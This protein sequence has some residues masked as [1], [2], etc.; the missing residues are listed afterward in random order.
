[1]KKSLASLCIVSIL[2]IFSACQSSDLDYYTGSV[3][4]DSY[5]VSTEVGG[6][7][8]EIYVK[9]GDT[10]KKGDKLARINVDS[11]RLELGR[12]QAQSGASKAALDKTFKG[13]RSEEI[14]KAR[15][16]VNQQE[17]VV[18][19]NQQDYNYRLEN[20]NTIAQLYESD[21]ASEQSL[22]D[23]KAVLDAASSKLESSRQQLAY[24]REQL[25][26]VQNG[27]TKE[28]IDISKSNLDA[29][30]W[31]IKSLEDNIAKEFVYANSDGVIESL[32][33]LGGEYAPIF[34][35][36]ANINNLSNLWVK[37]Y[38]EEKNLGNVKLGKE[39]TM[40][41][42]LDGADSIKGKVVYI[43]SE[44]EFT[45]KNIESKENKQ[46]IVYEVKIKVLDHIDAVKPGV[47][48]D[49]YL[50]DSK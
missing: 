26:L 34:T 3:E 24:L 11:L 32:N 1:M 21:A 10:V 9:E 28:D 36:I 39:V 23:S 30:Q 13:S 48:V 2:F 31:S 8:E 49:V 16:Q 33:Y 50:G 41:A 46:E 47:L 44:G 4:S 29:A 22:K 5:S 42:G 45:P 43:A 6:I 18:S 27:S 38:V 15:I 7:I 19:S 20:H 40:D 37:I 12:L 17:T 14:E 35:R 25:Q